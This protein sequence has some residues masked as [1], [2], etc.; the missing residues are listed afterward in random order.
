[1]QIDPEIQGDLEIVLSNLSPTDAHMFCSFLQSN[2]I[3]AQTGDAHTVQAN[4][5]WKDAVGGAKVRVPARFAAQA[6]DMIAAQRR[7]EYELDD[8]FDPGEAA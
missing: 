2:G 8:D 3:P 7:G 4:Y 1:M 5:L 6:R